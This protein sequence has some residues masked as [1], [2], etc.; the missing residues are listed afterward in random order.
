MKTG[1]ISIL[2]AILLVLTPSLPASASESGAITITMTGVETVISISLDKTNWLL[3]EVIEDTEYKTDP[4]ATW[5]T[6]TNAGNVNVALSTKGAHAIFI[7]GA[8]VMWY[9]SKDGTNE[10]SDTGSYPEY[11]LSYHI[12]M[13]SE[14]SYTSITLT[15]TP[16]K[17][18]GE[19]I[20]LDVDAQK[21]FGL[22]LLTPDS[23]PSGYIG[24]E[25]TTHITISAVPA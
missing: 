14:E 11:A 3:G 20:T 13:D 5:C 19:N 12:A 24:K 9:L 15:E 17:K 16:M 21:Q 18:G 8:D 25:M 10:G 23:F 1:I 6:I 7:N 22:K 4:E 2:G